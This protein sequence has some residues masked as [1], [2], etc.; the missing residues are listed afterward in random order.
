MS[1]INS[2]VS[3]VV[4]TPVPPT[5]GWYLTNVKESQKITYLLLI[6]ACMTKHI[7]KPSIEKAS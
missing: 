5:A 2:H 4:F 3:V 1:V 6:K 7:N